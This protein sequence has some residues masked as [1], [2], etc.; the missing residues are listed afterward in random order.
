MKRTIVF[1]LFFLLI[2]PLSAWGAPKASF[3]S[4]ETEGKRLY[5][6]KDYTPAI[7]KFLQALKIKEKPTLYF[8]LAQCYRLTDQ[9]QQA[10]KYYKKFRPHIKNL[11]GLTPQRKLILLEE[12]TGHIETI[13]RLLAER[14]KQ[15]RLAEEK[16]KR[17]LAQ[18]KTPLLPKDGNK[19]SEKPLIPQRPGPLFSQWWFWTGVG[20]TALFTV[21]TIFFGV[22]TLS[23][24]SEWE[25]TGDKT[26]RDDARQ[27]QNY[28]D[29][30]LGGAIV[31]GAVTAVFSYFH[32]QK[33]KNYKEPTDNKKVSFLVNCTSAF[34]GINM[35]FTF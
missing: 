30:A 33:I 25:D 19:D 21:S 14:A 28:T 29:I 3:K 16:R 27:Y 31:A 4:L 9:F 32:L 13:T 1:S 26:L 12:V 8:N 15:K 11:K 23:T 24:N 34:C 22:K 20:A 2:S 7:V 18:N 35:G 5:A 6:A 17:E 10:L